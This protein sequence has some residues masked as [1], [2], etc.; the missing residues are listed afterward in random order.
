MRKK[1]CLAFNIL[2]ISL[3]LINNSC[4]KEVKTETLVIMKYPDGTSMKEEIYKWRGN[5]KLKIKEIGYFPNGL[6]EYEGEV[7]EEQKKHGVWTYWHENG[8]KW[9]EENY[10]NNMLHG[11]FIEWYK[12]G[13]ISFE[14]EYS[15]GIPSGEWIFW[16]DQ[17]NKTKKLIYKNGKVAEE[18]T[19]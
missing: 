19:Y 10:Q 6:I 17:G 11:K 1:I 7:N 4:E 12:S 5:I 2:F 18:K 3:L 14:G 13:E 16:D 8:N 9:L 15:D